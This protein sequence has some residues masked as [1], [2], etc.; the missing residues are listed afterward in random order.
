M[1]K[2]QRG[3]FWYPK[4]GYAMHHL[5]AQALIRADKPIVIY[6]IET[7]GTG[8]YAYVVQFAGLKLKPTNGRYYIT[9]QLN[10]LIK[11]PIPMPAGASAV[12]HITDDM[13][14]D[15]PEED[16]V[17]D[18]IHEFFKDS[19]IAGYNHSTFDNQMIDHMYERTRGD[20]F[21]P[22]ENVDAL[23]L[24]RGL[25]NRQESQGFTLGLISELYGIK[26]DDG[27]QLHDALAD[28]KVTMKTLWALIR[29]YM[30]LGL[31]QEFIS[32][33][34][35]QRLQITHM[36]KQQFSKENNYVVID[37]CSPDGQFGQFRYEIYDKRFTEIQGNLMAFT[38][39]ETFIKDAD[40]FAGGD[41]AKFK[42]KK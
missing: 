40:I 27:D 8:K 28:T 38:D 21:V 30:D 24:A 34:S 15:M 19:L 6:D 41:I 23:I 35:K 33:S 31:E 25:V 13:L 4:S 9:E 7:T 29:D 32:M 2:D 1:L 26:P 39:M 11:P 17:V 14:A 36:T 18:T 12:N 22:K 5:F 37:V 42:E 3:R 20:H 16:F 10:Q